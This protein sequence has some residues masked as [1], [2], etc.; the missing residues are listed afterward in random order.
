[1][2]IGLHKALPNTR[3][4]NLPRGSS[5]VFQ[6]NLTSF[7]RS[8]AKSFNLV[9]SG[10]SVNPP[11]SNFRLAQTAAKSFNLLALARMVKG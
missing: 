6:G 8:A 1:V 11:F 3:F 9:G 2:S 4:V 7:T 10:P 5:R